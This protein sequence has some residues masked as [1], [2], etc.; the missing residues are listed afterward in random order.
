MVPPT[1]FA[2][3]GPQ[4][5]LVRFSSHEDEITFVVAQARQAAQSGSVAVL[6]RRGVTRR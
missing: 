6:V 5:A 2:A 4:P 3:D 1:E